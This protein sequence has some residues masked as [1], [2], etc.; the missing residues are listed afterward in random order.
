M[1]IR[2]ERVARLLQRE[3]AALLLSDFS[4][5]LQGMV[6]VT[7]TRVT[8]DL[9]IVYVYVSI[10]GEKAEARQDLFHRLEELKPRVRGALAQRIR[11][12]VRKIPDI[13][14]FLDETLEQAQRIEDLFEQIRDERSS[15]DQD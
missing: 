3:I 14:F 4:E 5:Q 11:H 13:R 10:L 2:T 12:Q 1:S 15:R 9:G 6:T 7:G 8:K